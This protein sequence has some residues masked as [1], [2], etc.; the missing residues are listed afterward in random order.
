M[1]S[2][3]TRLLWELSVLTCILQ[4]AFPSDSQSFPIEDESNVQLQDSTSTYNNKVD[5]GD[6]DNNE[7]KVMNL[8]ENSHL[9]LDLAEE[10]DELNE[11]FTIHSRIGEEDNHIHSKPRQDENDLHTHHSKFQ[12]STL[13]SEQAI[14]VCGVDGTVYTIDAWSG[15]LRG[16]FSSGDPLIQRRHSGKKETNNSEG[17]D[18]SDQIIPGLDGNLYALTSDNSDVVSNSLASSSS[19]YKMNILPIKVQDI[20]QSPYRT[21]SKR[22]KEKSFENWASDT[23]WEHSFQNEDIKDYE[24]ECGMVMGESTVKIYAI[25]PKSGTVQWMQ[26]PKGKER[27]FT[28]KQAY[29]QQSLSDK[30]KTILLKREDFSVR[31]VNLDSGDEFWQVNLA[32]ISDL[33]FYARNEE[34]YSNRNNGANNLGLAKELSYKENIVSGI[35]RLAASR[36]GIPKKINPHKKPTV[37]RDQLSELTNSNFVTFPSIVKG[38]DGKSFI[39]ID[40]RT[41][42]QLWKKKIEST[43]AFIHGVGKD[44]VDLNVMGESDYMFASDDTRAELIGSR[45]KEHSKSDEK[46]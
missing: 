27:G 42:A 34:R 16:L 13:Q 44:W 6:K 11:S 37:K 29:R 30:V 35:P 25:D 46:L 17:N 5:H 15:Q 22:S 32:V 8:D 3:K 36:I 9:D 31:H 10:F 14:V 45:V 28:S 41:G 19:Q 38:S 20:V 18:I 12:E 39:A 21:C 33:S 24:V 2:R 43:I 23:F 4:L 40:D 7:G 1:R 26:D